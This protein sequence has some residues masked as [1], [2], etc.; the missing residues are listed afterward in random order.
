[1]ETS[2]REGVCKGGDITRVE[3][4]QQERRLIAYRHQLIRPRVPKR[5]PLLRILHHDLLEPVPEGVEMDHI[6][7]GAEFELNRCER[8]QILRVRDPRRDLL[9]MQRHVASA[10]A[11]AGH[12]AEK[13]TQSGVFYQRSR[14]M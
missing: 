2:L 14:K 7:G 13:A 9:R 10:V 12:A 3:L 6:E 11:G 1:M 4:R 5:S 8:R